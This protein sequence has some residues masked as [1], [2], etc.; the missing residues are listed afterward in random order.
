MWKSSI[1]FDV[2]AVKASDMWLLQTSSCVEAFC[3]VAKEHC[4]TTN[5]QCGTANVAAVYLRLQSSCLLLMKLRSLLA[6]VS[7][8]S[9]L[10]NAH[11]GVAE[12]LIHVL[13]VQA[14]DTYDSGC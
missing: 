1:V 4:H 2:V 7:L 12:L 9:Q 13:H 10:H 6:E 8:S 11:P 3:R 5:R 14:S